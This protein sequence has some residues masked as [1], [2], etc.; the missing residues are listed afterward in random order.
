[1]TPID[2]PPSAAPRIAILGGGISGLTAAYRLSELLPQA[3]IELFE[4]S[5]RLG[6]IL[7][8]VTR[9]GFLIEQ[10]ADNFLI[11]PPAA[12]DLC[13]H[14]GLQSDLLTTDESRRRAFV[15]RSGRLVP[16]PEGFYLMSPRKLWPIL[17]SSALS[18]RGKLRLLLEPFVPRR[19]PNLASGNHD[20]ESDESVADFARRRLGREVFEQLVQPLVAGI[21]TADPERLSMAAT[22]PQFVEFERTSGSLLRATLKLRPRAAAKADA[23]SMDHSGRGA[24]GARYGLFVTPKDGMSSLIGKIASRLARVKVHLDAPI[25]ELNFNAD[26]WRLQL[27]AFATNIEPSDFD[28]AI[29]ALPA[30]AAAKILDACDPE[31]AAELAAIEYAGC[32]VVSLGFRRTQI[33][34]PLDGFGFV[35]PETERR[36]IIAGSFASLKFPGRAPEHHVLIRVFIGGALQ[37]EMLKLSDDELIRI[38]TE[39][40]VDLLQITGNPVISDVARWPASMPQYHVGHLARVNRIEQR[41][42]KHPTLA[43]AGNAYHGVGIPHCVASGES[44]VARIAAACLPHAQT[45]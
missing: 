11:K 44:A 28:A 18:L 20:D 13:R 24:S 22:M 7:N 9:G 27:H 8:T 40:L 37:P 5:G 4:A 34:H 38:A 35:V 17:T 42:A 41:M 25:S 45:R 6:G 33:S 19:K 43:L 26:K 3:V 1:M 30:P 39:E 21:Y 36:R 14:V 15:V 16:I 12:L 23:D 31:L 29:I 10:S 32:A 2:T